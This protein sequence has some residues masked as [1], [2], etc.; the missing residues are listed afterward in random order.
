M[1][2]GSSMATGP[3]LAEGRWPSRHRAPSLHADP[4]LRVPFRQSDDLMII[5]PQKRAG[6]T[7]PQFGHPHPGFSQQ[8]A[9]ITRMAD[10]LSRRVAKPAD[11]MAMSATGC[12]RQLAGDVEPFGEPG[13]L[14]AKLCSNPVRRARRSAAGIGRSKKTRLG[15][16]FGSPVGRNKADIHQSIPRWSRVR[17]LDLRRVRGCAP[18]RLSVRCG[19][20]S[21]AIWRSH[22]HDTLTDRSIF[23]RTVNRDRGFGST[24][25]MRG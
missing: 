20:K 21:L 2:P 7:R 25:G 24:V 6:A 10:M 1:C 12:F 16:R 17:S 3:Y 13:Q 9:D 14:S 22:E 15:P 23:A 11:A 18:Q 5:V 4:M 19:G 8:P